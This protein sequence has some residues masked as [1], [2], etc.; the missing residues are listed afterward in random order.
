MSGDGLGV[1]LDLDG[2]LVD[3]VFWHVV[4]WHGALHEAGYDVPMWQIHAGI[5]MGGDRLLSWLLGEH[6][7]DADELSDVHE[8]RFLEVADRLQPTNGAI[9]L[10]ADLERRGVAFVVATSAGPEEREALLAAL[11]RPDLPTTDSGDVS[12]SKPGPELLV[13]AAGQLVG[14]AGRTSLRDDD[15]KRLTMVG[16]SPWDAEAG[17]RAGVRTVAVRCGGFGDGALRRAGAMQIVD[18]PRALVGRL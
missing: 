18:D 16:D 3:S 5:G 11:D 4:C 2:T 7:D 6:P 9:P 13:A 1:I 12:S 10:L 17:H 8:R 15:V 14:H